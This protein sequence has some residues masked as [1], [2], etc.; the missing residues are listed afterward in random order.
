MPRIDHGNALQ[1][2]MIRIEE[3]GGLIIPP[4]FRCALGIKAGDE[5]ILRRD[6]HEL[7]IRKK[8]IAK[9]HARRARR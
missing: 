8:P 2:I 7:C 5:V 9:G 1:D 3:D 6:D 4:A